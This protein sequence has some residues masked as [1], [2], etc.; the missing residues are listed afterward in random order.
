MP[1]S[2]CLIAISS[3]DKPVFGVR[4]TNLCNLN[5]K[6]RPVPSVIFFTNQLA[7]MSQRK[8]FNPVKRIGSK[9]CNE[10]FSPSSGN[11]DTCSQCNEKVRCHCSPHVRTESI[12]T[13]LAN[14]TML[15]QAHQNHRHL[16]VFVYH[17]YQRWNSLFEPAKFSNAHLPLFEG[18]YAAFLIIH[19]SYDFVH[20]SINPVLQCSIVYADGRKLD[21]YISTEG[22]VFLKIPST[23]PPDGADYD[24]D[25]GLVITH[26]R[27]T[28]TLSIEEI[29]SSSRGRVL[30]YQSNTPNN[31]RRISHIVSE[32]QDKDGLC[33]VCVLPTRW[34]DEQKLVKLKLS[35][36]KEFSPHLCDEAQLRHI[37]RYTRDE[38]RIVKTYVAALLREI[39]QNDER[40]HYVMCRAWQQNV[41]PIRSV[42]HTFTKA[43]EQLVRNTV[44][45]NFADSTENNITD[46]KS[47]CISDSSLPSNVSRPSNFNENDE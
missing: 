40:V 34:G 24:A 10:V 35:D 46:G 1:K 43:F 44:S 16:C 8:N 38:S 22:R 23:Q 27:L 20:F 5:S 36:V 6:D 25:R 4:L 2:C 31:G 42:L 17:T 21:G 26:V 9:H 18:W 3:K 39:A 12:H 19:K 11:D 45:S 28:Q 33:T 7:C 15:P 13:L 30:G 41:P 32:E 37:R 29:T 47:N 14:Q